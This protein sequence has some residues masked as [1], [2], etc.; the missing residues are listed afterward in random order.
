[1]EETAESLHAKLYPE[2]AAKQEYI[3]CAA[4]HFED[5]RKYEHQP[6]NINSGFV[7]AGHRHH[8]VYA[9]KMSLIDYIAKSDTQGFIT[10]RDRFVD[11]KEAGAIAFQA[12]QISK[13]TECLFSEDLY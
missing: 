2:A 13:E 6:K 1:M 12:G 5:G 7:I 4:I 3:T 9:I 10:S 11:R 8:N